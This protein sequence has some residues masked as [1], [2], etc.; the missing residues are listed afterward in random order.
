MAK[1]KA[2]K[3]ATKKKTA[4]KK[5]SPARKKNASMTARKGARPARQ[6]KGKPKPKPKPKKRP[7]KKP[8]KPKSKEFNVGVDQCSILPPSGHVQSKKDQGSVVFHSNDHCWLDFSDESV[9][10]FGELECHAGTNGPYDIQVDEGRTEFWIRE[11]AARVGPAD[12]IV[13]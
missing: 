3:K 9:L 4:A 6:A 8:Q 1:K 10:G 2:K 11:C 7:A 13:P 12:I 5:K